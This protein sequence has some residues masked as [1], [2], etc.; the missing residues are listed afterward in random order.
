MERADRAHEY[1][2][3]PRRLFV[4]HRS[5]DL[6]AVQQQ[7]DVQGDH[8]EVGER[9]RL[10]GALPRDA[11]AGDLVRP[12]RDGHLGARDHARVHS[13]PLETRVLGD[14]TQRLAQ[15][16]DVFERR[17]V[18]R[19]V[20]HGPGLEEGVGHQQEAV[21]VACPDLPCQRVFD[22]RAAED[23]SDDEDPTGGLQAHCDCQPEAR[24]RP[25]D[26]SDALEPAP[27]GEP[28]RGQEDRGE[29]DRPEH[30]H[31]PER[32]ATHPLDELA[33]DDGPDLTHGRSS[34]ARASPRTGPT[35]SMKIL[36][37]DASCSSK[38][39]SRAP[40]ATSCLSTS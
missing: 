5:H 31:H 22:S 40:D 28:Q 38:R 11:T 8:H 21:D 23:A 36:C 16:S 24:R 2:H 39:D 30:R 32:S 29:E 33:P 18:R 4:D 35:R 37:S 34:S 27:A 7:R 15:Q 26:D 17:Y 6:H 9:E 1:F 25:I 12:Q 14:A 13:G 10:A 20:L 3:H 19:A